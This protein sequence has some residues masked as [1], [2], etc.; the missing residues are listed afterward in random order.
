MTLSSLQSTISPNPISPAPNSPAPNSPASSILT[1]S[2][3]AHST[4][5]TEPRS[6]NHFFITTTTKTPPKTPP[7]P[8]KVGRIHPLNQAQSGS[9][10]SFVSE[11]NGAFSH[12]TDKANNSLPKDNFSYTEKATLSS[13]NSSYQDSSN[14]VSCN[15]IRVNSSECPI[16]VDNTEMTL[17]DGEDNSEF[18]SYSTSQRNSLMFKRDQWEGYSVSDSDP[19]PKAIS[20]H[21]LRGELEEDQCSVSGTEPILGDLKLC[22]E[23]FRQTIEKLENKTYTPDEKNIF[24]HQLHSYLA[25]IKKI[26]GEALDL[27]HS[28]Q[29]RKGEFPTYSRTSTPDWLHPSHFKER[30][31]TPSFVN[32]ELPEIFTEQK[33]FFEKIAMFMQGYCLPFEKLHLGQLNLAFQDLGLLDRDPLS[34]STESSPTSF[35]KIDNALNPGQDSLSGSDFIEDD[36][37]TKKS[38]SRKTKIPAKI[39]ENERV[40]NQRNQMRKNSLRNSPALYYRLGLI[41]WVTYKQTLGSLFDS[42]GVLDRFSEM[43]NKLESCIK[44]SHQNFCPAIDYKII[45]DLALKHAKKSLDS[46]LLQLNMHIDNLKIAEIRCNKKT[47]LGQLDSNL[48]GPCSKDQKNSIETC[49]ES[50]MDNRAVFGGEEK[51]QPLN[52]LIDRSDG[53]KNQ[54]SS[55]FSEASREAY[56]RSLHDH[57]AKKF[58]KNSEIRKKY[59][60]SFIKNLISFFELDEHEYKSIL[61]ELKNILPFLKKDETNPI[62][63]FLHLFKNDIFKEI[64]DQINYNFKHLKEDCLATEQLSLANPMKTALFLEKT[65]ENTYQVVI[66]RLALFMKENYQLSLCWVVNFQLDKMAGVHKK[67]TEKRELKINNMDFYVQ[68]V[69][70]STNSL[71]T[72]DQRFGKLLQVIKLMDIEIEKNPFC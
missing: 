58:T 71:R 62:K 31:A 12:A 3:S 70:S 25:K 19:I 46:Y 7:M 30:K 67:E 57:K 38:L 44:I 40:K 51:N 36:D 45:Y 50:L 61:S 37:F 42:E 18:G 69:T 10:D 29:E 1:S 24:L 34:E 39:K 35:R 43:S 33:D 6:S 55:F 64:V 21:Q 15:D 27:N 8:I 56:A 4:P 60:P 13:T 65:E 68:N 23:V 26:V 49:L 63:C 32:L 53:A 48:T 20:K 54:L 47:F 17:T 2:S 59:Y 41:D 66:Q 16:S 52:H 28:N 72:H 9:S 14:E 11:K 22:S 5:T